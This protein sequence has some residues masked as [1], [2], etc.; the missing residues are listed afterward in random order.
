MY[1]Q[2]IVPIP[3][4][5]EFTYICPKDLLLKEG[6]VVLV[7]FGKRKEEI[8]I[9]S[10]VF[11]RNK[12][13]ISIKHLKTV[14][15]TI[16]NI[17][18]KSSIFEFLKWVSDYT[19]Y[20]KGLILK[21][22]LS[23]KKIVSYQIK[24]TDEIKKNYI[25]KK[26]NLNLEQ[27]NIF[28]SIKR[29][30]YK[31]HK[32]IVLEGVTGSGKTEVYFK[33]IQHILNLDLQVLILLPEISLTPQI[34]KRFLIHFGFS[35]DV[36]HSKISESKKCKIWHR[37]Y[38]GRSKIIIGAR[39]SL[40]LPFK[41]LG[42]I[43]VDEEHDISYKQEDGVR[44]HGRDMAIVRSK[45]ENIPI[46][47]STATPSIETYFNIFNKKY[48]HVFLSKQYSGY[49]L[50]NINLVNLK[51]ENLEKNSWI[52]H[53]IIKEIKNCIKNKEQ[54]LLFLN[55]R[56]YSPLTICG[57][58]GY[59]FQCN[60]CSSWLVMHSVK[61]ILSC[62]HCGFTIS[63]KEEC[64]NCKSTNSLKY[65]G[66][67]IER[68]AEELYSKFP[69]SKIEIMSSENMN[70]PNKIK[71]I[72]DRIENKQIDILVGTQILA[73]GY[74]FPNLSLVGVLDAD[75]GL[76]GGDLRASEHTFNLL[77][78]V[79]GRAG[80]TKSIGKVFIQTYFIENLLITSLISRDRELFLKRVLLERKQFNLPPFSCLIAI[81]I[82]GTSKANTLNFSQKIVKKFQIKK[83]ISILGPVE[84]PLFLLRGK[85]RYRI[86]IKG[87][88]R[89]ELN[90]FAKNWLKDIPIPR[91]IRVIIDVDPYSF[92]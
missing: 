48:N 54:S 92:M 80:R 42:L 49:D 90:A 56:G 65:I 27:K 79:S 76:M 25:S 13:N 60:Y 63:I 67:G 28:D 19:L 50:P 68:V 89:R 55:R 57:S 9:V 6:D 43:I 10:K 8:A 61:K 62:H 1:C 7:P 33:A 46:I 71:K 86:L 4:E 52:S 41:N 36:W 21:M 66:P 77:Q 44:Y 83:D 38:L 88:K 64:P 81:I 12:S 16:N 78:Q 20:P 40:F 45:F 74:H 15:K 30:L 51:K 29:N 11:K 22:I 37:C 82:S 72:I 87:N 5:K 24:N 84:A 14:K 75:A 32:T 39:S 85:F 34:E 91:N 17:N 69:N 73:K 26:I 59:R 3:F 58:C 18:L 70:T 47:L 53:K 2:V 31:K 35:P 23:N